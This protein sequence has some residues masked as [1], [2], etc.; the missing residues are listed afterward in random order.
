MLESE[1]PGLGCTCTLTLPAFA[2]HQDDENH[3][4]E[5]SD[6]GSNRM[7]DR[8]SIRDR[9][10]S[11]NQSNL[12]SNI[13]SSL[14]V[15]QLRSAEA[16]SNSHR[17]SEDTPVI[18]QFNWNGMPS[19]RATANNFVSQLTESFGI[20]VITVGAST[21]VVVYN[22]ED[23]PR[24]DDVD[25]ALSH[26]QRFNTSITAAKALTNAES[27]SFY[28]Y[29]PTKALLTTVCS[30]DDNEGVMLAHDTMAGEAFRTGQSRRLSSLDELGSDH[31]DDDSLRSVDA[32]GGNTAELRR[33]SCRLCVPVV[34]GYGMWWAPAL[35]HQT[36]LQDLWKI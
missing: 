18:P 14:S 28:A 21:S 30:T 11:R 29:D 15:R 27:I 25:P 16:V 8:R 24:V 34:D 7:E 12:S 36:F 22:P 33:R 9:N 6:F 20:D 17:S 23:T 19:S 2:Y 31:S 3:R 13:S 26:H 10:H 32:H 4:R 1:G 5:S 35:C